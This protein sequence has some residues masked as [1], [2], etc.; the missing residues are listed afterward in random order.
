MSEP[1]V[2]MKFSSYYQVLK[3]AQEKNEV[4]NTSIY[5]TDNGRVR[6]DIDLKKGLL[7][8]EEPG[9]N[10]KDKRT[11]VEYVTDKLIFRGSG[12]E[13][14]NTKFSEIHGKKTFACDLNQNG[15]IDSNEIFKYE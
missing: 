10:S 9:K 5:T 1:K 3:N 12:T 6:T 13:G 15:I 8:L 7:S 4:K 11:D 14:Q 2:G